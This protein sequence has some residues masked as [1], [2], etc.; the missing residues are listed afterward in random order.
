M[1]CWLHAAMVL[2]YLSARIRALAVTT[3]AGLR[4]RPQ[5]E[6]AEPTLT[7]GSVSSDWMEVRMVEMLCTGLHLSCSTDQTLSQLHSRKPSR[8]ANTQSMGRKRHDIVGE[9]SRLRF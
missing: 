1:R 4:C 5:L 6:T 8:V 7:L 9:A 3:S 2:R